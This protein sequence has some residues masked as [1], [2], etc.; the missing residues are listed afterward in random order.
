MPQLSDQPPLLIRNELEALNRSLDQ[1]IPRKMAGLNLLIAT[2]NIRSFS[3]LTRKGTA[4]QSDSPKR[5]LRGLRAIYD[6][7]SLLMLSPSR[8]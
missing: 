6:I 7:I 4:L 2:W 1:V 5:D 3:S 8:R